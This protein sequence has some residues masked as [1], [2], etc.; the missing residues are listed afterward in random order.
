MRKNNDDIIAKLMDRDA[1]PDELLSLS[2]AEDPELGLPGFYELSKWLEQEQK[3][4]ERSLESEASRLTDYALQAID[5]EILREK[6][7]AGKTSWNWSGLKSAFF[8]WI[9][10]YFGM[11]PARDE[12]VFPNRC[13]SQEKS[14]PAKF[15]RYAVPIGF[16]FMIICLVMLPPS[17]KPSL[18]SPVYEQVRTDDAPCLIDYSGNVRMAMAEQTQIQKI[19]DTY[20]ALRTGSIWLDVQKNGAGFAVSTDY[21]EVRVLGTSFGVSRL[22]DPERYMIECV[23][24]SVQITANEISRTLTA[25]NYI[26]LDREGPQKQQ[27]RRQGRKKAYW[28]RILEQKEDVQTINGLVAYWDMDSVENNQ[29]GLIVKDLGSNGYHAHADAEDGYEPHLEFSPSVYPEIF[30][31]AIQIEKKDKSWLTI[32]NPEKL[33]ELKDEVTVMAWVRIDEKIDGN[34]Y[35]ILGCY[36]V[37]Y[38]MH[39]GFEGLTINLD[40]GGKNRD[41]AGSSSEVL[42]TGQWIHVA[43]SWS[44]EEKKIRFYANGE[45]IGE[46]KIDVERQYKIMDWYIGRNRRYMNEEIKTSKPYYFQGMIDEVRIYDRVL[47]E[48]EIREISM[49][50]LWEE[51]VHE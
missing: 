5:V 10:D 41:A 12:I 24:G 28:V 3:H 45:F 2:S 43:A 15:W 18:P 8:S 33:S 40:M 46:D 7:E 34:T 16:V 30:G 1:D 29:A 22:S 31:Q 4:D 47:S 32:P 39:F 27:L 13:S 35:R 23:E 51:A 44:K 19:S 20:T 9:I 48:D 21:G 25:G 6:N 14:S 42:E 49:I 36:D 50:S 11:L 26:I 37:L 17:E 38:G